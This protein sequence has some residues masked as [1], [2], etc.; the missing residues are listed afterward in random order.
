MAKTKARL[1]APNKI[2]PEPAIEKEVEAPEKKRELS[3]IVFPLAST[4]PTE[5][6]SSLTS[7]AEM[8]TATKPLAG[9]AN[10]ARLMIA[11]QQKVGNARLSRM[12]GTGEP[13]DSPAK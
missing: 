12:F 6:G 3:Q 13:P 4:P 5:D 10:R 8:L 1:K 2:R 7:P 11:M 9:N